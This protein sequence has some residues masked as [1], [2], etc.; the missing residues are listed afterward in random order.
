MNQ[1]AEWTNLQPGIVNEI[2]TNGVESS[3]LEVPP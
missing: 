1:T 3:E 2:I